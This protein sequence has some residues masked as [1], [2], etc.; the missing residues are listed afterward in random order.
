MEGV[1][2]GHAFTSLLLAFNMIHR[3]DSVLM[4]HLYMKLLGKEKDKNVPRAI[5]LRFWSKK[6]QCK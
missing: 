2:F 3:P 6:K 1:D 4:V 5:L